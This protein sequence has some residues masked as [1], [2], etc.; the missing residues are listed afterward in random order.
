ML[1]GVGAAMEAAGGGVPPPLSTSCGARLDCLGAR[2]TPSV[3]HR[4]FALRSRLRAS[5]LHPG[6]SL[7]R[8]GGTVLRRI[9]LLVCATALVMW[10]GTIPAA[11]GHLY[12]SGTAG[13]SGTR[14]GVWMTPN[15]TWWVGKRVLTSTYEGGVNNAA[16]GQYGPTDLTVSVFIASSCGDNPDRAYDTCVYDE[17]Y[18]NNGLNGWNACAGSTSG[19][20]PNQT[21]SKQW[22]RIN[23]AYSPPANRIACHELGHSVGLQHWGEQ[24]SCMKTTSAGGT[25]SVLHQHDRD[26]IN[27]R[28]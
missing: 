19:S 4:G 25:S 12:S 6:Q 27:Q 16:L 9:S 15:S 18:G 14:N 13:T 24:G 1:R 7:W 11:A 10:A 28:Y 26:A 17:N 2:Y 3:L 5:L 20:H 23:L 21:C 8:C 22:V